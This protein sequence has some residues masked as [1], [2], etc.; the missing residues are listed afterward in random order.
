MLLLSYENHSIPMKYVVTNS[1]NW[2]LKE[3]QPTMKTVFQ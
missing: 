2:H 3:I 1:A